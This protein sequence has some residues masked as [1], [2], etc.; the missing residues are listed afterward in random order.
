MASFKL[1][2]LTPVI[3]K[4]NNNYEPYFLTST[5]A[6]WNNT[7][8][9]KEPFSSEIN[10]T[11]SFNEKFKIA[12]NSQKT[13][14]F[15]MYRKIWRD[16]AWSINPFVD[17][18][19]VGTQILLVDQQ[20]N[21]HLFTIANIDYTFNQFNIQYNFSCQDSFN[22]QLA[23]QNE[24][25][26]I[27][28]DSSRSDFIGAK[29]L[30]WWIVNKIIP[31]CYITYNYVPSVF[32]LAAQK[33]IYPKEDLFPSDNLYPATGDGTWKDSPLLTQYIQTNT[34]E[35]QDLS[36][37][38][39]DEL[40]KESASLSL[41]KEPLIAE[42]FQETIPFSCS[43]SNAAAALISLVENLECH[44]EVYEH[45][46][47]R[48]GKGYL[49]QYFWFAPV[50]NDH[51]TGLKYAPESNV[52]QFS[53]SQ[54]GSALTSVLNVSS[55]TR[56]DEE[57]GMIP[58][59]SPFFKNFIEDAAWKT[60][61][62]TS[63]YYSSLLEGKQETISSGPSIVQLED[64]KCC[65][66]TLPDNFFNI[67]WDSQILFAQGDNI[68]IVFS[69]GVEEISSINTLYYLIAEDNEDNIKY[70]WSENDIILTDEI[71]KI[72][73]SLKWYV[74]IFSKAEDSNLSDW[75]LSGLPV[76]LTLQPIVSEE[77]RLFAEAAEDCPWLENKLFDFSYF[78]ET[79]ILSEQEYQVL[80]DIIYNELRII[81]GQ[82]L[83]YSK[84]YYDAL[85]EKTEMIAD[86][87]SALDLLGA[88]CQAEIIQPFTEEGKIKQ[89]V[90]FDKCYD[91]LLTRYSSL[92]DDTILGFEDEVTSCFNNYFNSQ[93]RFLKNIKNFRDHFNAPAKY[94]QVYHR[95]LSITIQ[96]E[97]PTGENKQIFFRNAL[98]RSVFENNQVKKSLYN[99]DKPLVDFYL[100]EG[101]ATV[102]VPIISLSNYY[103]F[104]TP[105]VQEGDI[106]PVQDNFNYNKD[107]VYFI[108]I[109]NYQTIF[110]PKEP[111]SIIT[112]QVLLNNVV[113]EL[114]LVQLTDKE[115]IQ[116]YLYKHPGD[117]HT[118]LSNEYIKFDLIRGNEDDILRSVNPAALINNVDDQ[119]W[120]EAWDAYKAYFPLSEIYYYG[121]KH[122]LIEEYDKEKELST[123]KI[124]R[125]DENNEPATNTN[126]KTYQ[127][128]PFVSYNSV[129]ENAGNLSLSELK[130]GISDQHGNFN[131]FSLQWNPV[132]IKWASGLGIAALFLPFLIPIT[133]ITS[134]IISNWASQSDNCIWAKDWNAYRDFDNRKEVK[135][136][137][138]NSISC[139]SENALYALEEDSW[140][141]H[142]QYYELLNEGETDAPRTYIDYY[143]LIAATYSF[144]GEDQTDELYIKKPTFYRLIKHNEKLNKNNSYV[145]CTFAIGKEGDEALTQENWVMFKDPDS[146]PYFDQFS[147]TLPT[148]FSA[149]QFYF[150]KQYSTPVNLNALENINNFWDNI[151]VC[152]PKTNTDDVD[153]YKNSYIFKAQKTEDDQNYQ[154]IFCVLQVEDYICSSIV[155]SE[156]LRPENWNNYQ[157]NFLEVPISQIYNNEYARVSILGQKDLLEPVEGLSFY[158]KTTTDSDFRLLTVDDLVEE[159]NSLKL[160][161]QTTYY[162]KI[163]DNFVRAYS[164]EQINNSLLTDTEDDYYYIENSKN[165]VY[166]DAAN[167][168]VITFDEN[169]KRF[170]T[171]VILQTIKKDENGISIL[172]AQEDIMVFDFENAIET[173][174][175]LKATFEKDGY[176]AIITLSDPTPTVE[177]QNLTNGEFWWYYHNN[178]HEVLREQCAIIETDLTLYWEEALAA[179]KGCQFFLPDHW[180]ETANNQS[181]HFFGKIYNQSDVG[182]ITINPELIPI[183][184]VYRK[185]HN[186]QWTNRLPR[187]V[188]DFKEPVTKYLTTNEQLTNTQ[189]IESAKD[190]FEDH[191][192]Y[193]QCWNSLPLKYEFGW[194]SKWTAEE[195]GTQVY[196]I[197]ES[198]GTT[199]RDLLSIISQDSRF[200]KRYDLYNGW[201]G[202]KL[203]ILLTY[204]K[205]KTLPVYEELI[206]Q[207]NIVW[208]KL[209]KN[210]PCFLEKV[211]SNDSITSSEELRKMAR[212]ELQRYSRP[213]F[214]YNITINDVYSLWGYKS[215]MLNIGD[216]IL[217]DTTSYYQEFDRLTTSLNQYL[218]ITDISYDLRTDFGISVTVNNLKY[219]DKLMQQL[220]SLIR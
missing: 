4:N 164:I 125:L 151:T 82:L 107:N 137:E 77:D 1:I 168:D 169:E 25:Y 34:L 179:S 18:L 7:Q 50:K 116:V 118:R 200:S 3:N 43:G 165:F 87:E 212:L 99:G 220:V 24:N 192:A 45:L 172:K 216:P 8:Q 31:E 58:S 110:Y 55:T 48:D 190:L 186:G 188:L 38:N 140:S 32:G 92:S 159:E 170:E 89:P 2:L 198:G 88:H 113:T 29:T 70:V 156:T 161:P 102:K 62:F 117:Y 28:N 146:N 203:Y 64:Y 214:N 105:M 71:K 173:D 85:R 72:D 95:A 132:G 12:K 181:N 185:V 187:Y 162:S 59:I 40:A 189:K 208:R 129:W 183:V 30:D 9:Q 11:Y 196:Y 158:C 17:N 149:E 211:Y 56:N 78:V 101:K 178:E 37:K 69:K 22:Y 176:T 218:F 93:Q 6:E 207:K 184:S 133:L 204:F 44:I 96:E 154:M 115:L 13:L 163:K 134:P 68:S 14:S 123:Q 177:N 119:K 152:E 191:P 83:I 160:N 60:S 171:S 142:N 49:D 39:I 75:S 112:T 19:A 180:Q 94:S 155:N 147:T 90:E 103:N 153:T 91:E 143:N 122:K 74:G 193:V 209:V 41:I 108:D 52:Q 61:Q 135:D 174:S 54:T 157:S 86:I 42:Y 144:K 26:S 27:T 63:G 121:A 98:W 46:N 20:D 219:T 114:T 210:Y 206:N 197:H 104:Y 79:K 106:V 97:W 199:W 80:I 51:Y 23:R 194:S 167:L 67:A 195:A 145:I 130:S 139:D 81:N 217:L 141:K 15:S 35:L 111:E 21:H 148:R 131:Y 84:A 138:K 53:M 33:T 175:G 126:Y 205:E 109:E 166:L 16:D 128:I 124:V 150:L 5:F 201:Y 57:I 65:L 215:H 136:K 76:Y 120:V 36:I 73:N 182:K 100:Q 47:I 10:F 66:I 127:S 213:E 202:L